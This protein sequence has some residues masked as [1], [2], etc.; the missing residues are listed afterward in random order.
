[1]PVVHWKLTDSQ[2]HTSLDGFSIQ[3][4]DVAGSPEGWSVSKQILRGGL[5]E[6]VELI[7]IQ[8]GALEI[9]LVPTRGMGIWYVQSEGIRLGWESP[10]ARPVNPQF[11][12]LFDPSGMG[13]LEGFNELVCRCGLQSNGSPVFDEQQRLIHPLHGRIANLP[14]N[15]VSLSVDPHEGRIAV[16]GVIDEVRFHFQKLRLTSTLTTHFHSRSITWT[17][18]VQN[19]SGHE[20][21]MQMLYHVNVGAPILGKGATLRAPI[22]C[23]APCD[24]YTAQLGMDQWHTYNGP[25]VG[26]QQRSYFAQLLGDEDQQTRVLLR[27]SSGNAGVGLRFSVAELPY[28]TQWCNSAPS[29]DGYVTGIEPG[30]NFPNTRPFEQQNGRVVRLAPHER[31]TATV[32]LDL[33]V[34]QAEVESSDERVCQLQRGV[35]PVIHPR[36]L[37]EW[38]NRD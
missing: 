23:I 24:S 11:V 1:M 27:N 13:W 32:A 7:V 30:T 10:V 5:S 14:A 8:T 37:P 6:G 36:P 20:A 12:P 31:W 17:D 2:R 34:N 29:E 38:S 25:G 9:A 15:D 18:E 16:R 26:H 21:S 22:R 33:H 19:L 4:A 28:F 35:H 3:A